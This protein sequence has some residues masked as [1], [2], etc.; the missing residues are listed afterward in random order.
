MPR[1]VVGMK[2]GN[3]GT[4]WVLPGPKYSGGQGATPSGSGVA[5]G[6]T[7]GGWAAHAGCCLVTDAFVS[8]AL[9]ENRLC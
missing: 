7:A 1:P 3:G 9:G 6:G 5:G 4:C 2:G 8:I